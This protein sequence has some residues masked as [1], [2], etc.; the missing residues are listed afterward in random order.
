VFIPRRLDKFVRDATDDSTLSVR[1][2][3][4]AQQVRVNGDVCVDETQLVFEEDVV[5]RGGD[6]LVP[7]ESHSHIMLNKP[8]GV[9]STA[10]DPDGRADLRHFLA[11]MPRGVFPIGRLDRMTSG[12]LLFTSDGDLAHAVLHSDHHTEKVYWLWLNEPVADDDP[13]LAA[14][15]GGMLVRG[16]LAR[17]DSVAIVHRS[18]DFTE[19]H[20]K[21]SEGKNRQIRRMARA[22]DFHLH[23]LHRK[24]VGPLELGS[25]GPGEFRSLSPDEVRALW[26]ATGGRERVR[27]RKRAALL[28][29]AR[30]GRAAGLPDLR[31]ESWLA[32]VETTSSGDA[33]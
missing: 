21:L 7:R 14:L 17:V 31:L 3:I 20:V 30:S 1:D 2:S 9:T 4:R 28:R 5:I 25:L 12:L 22:L 10:R 23:G 26:Q 24:A 15:L 33:G 6:R 27:A 11:Q 19:L 32:Q 29:L 13:R 16:R 18:E 8:L